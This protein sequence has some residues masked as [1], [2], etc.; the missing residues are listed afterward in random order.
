MANAFRQ[1]EATC[2]IMQVCMYYN[3]VVFFVS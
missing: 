3:K 2:D 1:C